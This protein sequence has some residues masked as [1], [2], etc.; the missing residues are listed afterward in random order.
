MKRGKNSSDR[1][2]ENRGEDLDRHC[3]VSRHGR[4]INQMMTERKQEVV[5]TVSGFSAFSYLDAY[6]PLQFAFLY[7]S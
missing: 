2:P 7:T 1:P 5:P 3:S 4:R 6:M